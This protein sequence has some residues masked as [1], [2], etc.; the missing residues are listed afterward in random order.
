MSVATLEHSRRGGV[1]G[2]VTESGFRGSKSPKH[3]ECI[4]A[5]SS[6]LTLRTTPIVCAVHAPVWVQCVV[7]VG[8][9]RASVTLA[10]RRVGSNH[11][12]QCGHTF[13]SADNRDL[14]HEPKCQP[15]LLQHPQALT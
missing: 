3:V 13:H 15:E 9:P 11:T 14:L 8:L 1:S 4:M 6:V 12:I 2:A 5:E 7:A 10:E